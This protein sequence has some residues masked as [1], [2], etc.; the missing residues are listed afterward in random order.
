MFCNFYL[1]KNK[2]TDSN[3]ASP[4]AREKISADLESLGLKKNLMDI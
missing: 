1:V 2:K 4:E 3:S